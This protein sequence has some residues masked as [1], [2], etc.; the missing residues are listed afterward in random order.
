MKTAGEL[1]GEVVAGPIEAPWTR[2]AVI[3]DPRGAMFI[4][5]QFVPENKDLEA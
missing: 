5:S 2:F 1:G 3:K 4:A